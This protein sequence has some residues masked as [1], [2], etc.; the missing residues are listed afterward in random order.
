MG[1]GAAAAALSADDP[2]WRA[3]FGAGAR[4]DF[5][6]RWLAV[7]A[8]LIPGVQLGLVVLGPADKGPYTP[9]GSWPEGEGDVRRLAE[10]AERALVNRQGVILQN[11]GPGG[12]AHIAWPIKS[13]GHLHGVVALEVSARDEAESQALLRQLQWG[14]GWLEVLM[15]REDHGRSGVAGERLAVVLDLAAATVEQDGF[16]AGASTLVAEVATRLACERVSLGAVK[17]GRVHVQAMSHGSQFD[18]RTNLV[19]ALES[20]MEEALDQER[21]VAVPAP[22][23]GGFQISLAHEAFQ[24]QY[25]SGSLASVPFGRE[26]GI[27][28]VITLERPAARPIE[29]ETIELCE[30]LCALAGPVLELERRNERWIGRKVWVSLRAQLAKVTGPRH[31]ALKLSL[32]I[33]LLLV[34]FFSVADTDYEITSDSAIEAEVRRVAVAPFNGYVS[35][36][37][38]RAGDIVAEGDLLFLLDDRELLLQRHGYASQVDQLTKQYNQALAD[39]ER[40]EVRVLAARLDEVRAELDLVDDQLGRTRVTSPIEG[41]VVAGDMSQAIGAPVE[42]GQVVFEVAPLDAYRVIL[43]V[44]ERDVADLAVGQTGD[45][46]LSA[47]PTEPVPFTVTKITP[48]SLATEGRNYFRVEARIDSVDARLRP[49]MEGVS[50]VSIGE[51]KLIWV[52]THRTIDWLRLFFWTWA[53]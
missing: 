49:G 4:D 21:P 7:Q 28:G 36:A 22:P 34:L 52:W 32:A 39:G 48:V 2:A 16:E 23:D 15:H 30:A 11:A 3:F 26:G 19:R 47:F 33:L 51:R 14:A 29:P 31:G 46:V 17:K 37:P 20:A 10:V 40:A 6:R 45:L 24:R 18:K 41:L 42:R 35:E 8:Q 50:K 1:Q 13:E 5:C 9:A 44:D 12:R 38:F 43:E 25:G 27:Y 53:P